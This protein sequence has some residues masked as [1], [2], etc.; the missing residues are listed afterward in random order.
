MNYGLNPEGPGPDRGVC[1]ASHG[2]IVHPYFVVSGF[3][4]VVG[5]TGLVAW[6]F[7]TVAPIAVGLVVL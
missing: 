2:V 7:V 5:M 3:V 6:W 4:L 1:Y